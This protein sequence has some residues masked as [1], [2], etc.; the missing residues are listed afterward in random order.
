MH[1]RS[2]E[3]VVAGLLQRGERLFEQ[4]A[5]PRV[6]VLHGQEVTQHGCRRGCA[7]HVPG[8]AV[9][10]QALLQ[11]RLRLAW[12]PDAKRPKPVPLSARARCRGGRCSL[13]A[14]M[15]T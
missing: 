3:P 9:Q 2:G 10:R 11:Q 12:S 1:A 4:L 5:G 7:Q 13:L 15:S 6:L 14:R 8:L